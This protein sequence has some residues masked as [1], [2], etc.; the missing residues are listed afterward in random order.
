M[1]DNFRNVPGFEG[2]Y[3][4]DIS[5][6]EGRCWSVKRKKWLS[7]KCHKRDKRLYWQ[8]SK[9]GKAF[10]HQ[11][12]KWIALTY[13]ELV[14]N[15]YFDGACID[16]II[17]LSVGGT[18]HPTN[19]RW[20]TYKENSNNPITLK[21]LCTSHLNQNNQGLAVIQYTLDGKYVREYDSAAEAGRQTNISQSHI[22]KCCKGKRNIAG[23]KNG[24][25]YIWRYAEN[26]TITQ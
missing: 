10:S 3:K 18:N 15:E 5:T 26:N 20:V 16:H 2:L 6:P 1:I 25:K 17:P 12:A 11:A 9:K 21:N 23:V 4:I 13:P 14:Q 19:L 7:N 8:L 22:T 24:P